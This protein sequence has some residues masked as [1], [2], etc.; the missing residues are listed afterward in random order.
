MATANPSPTRIASPDKIWSMTVDRGC[1]GNGDYVCCPPGNHPGTIVGIFDVGTQNEQIKDA[2]MK[3]IHRLVV[4]FELT[5][6]RPDGRPFILAKKYTWSM[7]DNS[8]LYKDVIN[9]TGH[10]FK[11]GEQF[12]PTSINGL[13]VLVAVSNSQPGD[14]SYHDVSSVARYP[15]GFPEIAPTHRPV[16]WSVLSD[17]PFPTGL[18]WLPYIYGKSVQDLANASVEARARNGIRPDF[19]PAPATSPLNPPEHKDDQDD[20]IPF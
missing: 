4:V 2:G 9:I 12:N 14:R 6:K 16:S 7:R 13:P 18:D 8:Y 1:G 15:E 10:A 5:K 3:P 17:E 11:D 20:P 19:G